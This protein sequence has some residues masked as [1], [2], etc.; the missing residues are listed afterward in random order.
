MVPE[1]GVAGSGLKDLR[2]DAKQLAK[3]AG[4]YGEGLTSYLQPPHGGAANGTAPLYISGSGKA[5]L[6]CPRDTG[7]T[8]RMFGCDESRG[9]ATCVK[10]KGI[11]KCLCDAGW[12]AFRGRCYPPPEKCSPKPGHGC[13][14]QHD[15]PRAKGP[16]DCV[17]GECVCEAGWCAHEGTCYWIQGWAGR[18]VET[19]GVECPRQ[20]G[21]AE[22]IDGYCVCKEG[23]LVARGN[24][25][26]CF[27]WP[28]NAAEDK[29][30]SRKAV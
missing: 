12:C 13:R 8:C 3:D 26:T 25:P 20:Q 9:P 21:L 1:L 30:N 14:R 6:Y 7:G 24:P 29:V 28:R 18:C 19:N 17:N 23:Y 16:M 11:K 5:G 15:C 22:C 2:R 10:H 4:E 27:A